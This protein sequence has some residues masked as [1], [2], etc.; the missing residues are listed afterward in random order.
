MS[1]FQNRYLAHLVPVLE[2]EHGVA[3][4]LTKGTLVSASFTARR[5]PREYDARAEELALSVATQQRTYFLPIVDCVIASETVEPQAGWI[6]TEG[7][8]TWQIHHPDDST[9]AVSESSN[10]YEWVCHCRQVS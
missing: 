1:R 5:S 8:E 2:R 4:T 10:N 9:P 6:I 3:V 7:T